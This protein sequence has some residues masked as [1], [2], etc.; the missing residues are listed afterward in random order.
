MKI[1]EKRPYFRNDLQYIV[2]NVPIYPDLRGAVHELQQALKSV[3]DNSTHSLI[4]LS[5]GDKVKKI[6]MAASAQNSWI[7]QVNS[8]IDLFREELETLATLQ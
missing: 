7:G 3:P 5:L 6:E 1:L 4:V 2:L 8:K